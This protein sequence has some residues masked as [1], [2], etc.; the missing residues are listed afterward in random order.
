MKLGGQWITA[1]QYQREKFWVDGSIALRKIVQSG[2]SGR[3][4]EALRQY[5]L[6]EAEYAGT[7]I[8]AKAIAE[9]KPILR[10]YAATIEDTILSHP[11]L[12]KQR[13]ARL[14]TLEPIERE[15]TVAAQKA[16]EEAYLKKVEEERKSGTKWL[17]IDPLNLEELG[18]AKETVAAETARI[19]AIDTTGAE[20]REALLRQIDQAIGEGRLKSASDLVLEASTTLKDSPHLKALTERVKTEIAR[21]SEDKAAADAARIEAE[22]R[23]K[24]ANPP[25]KKSSST[26]D[27]QAKLEEEM[28]SPVAKAVR[29]SQL[30]KRVAKDGAATDQPSPNPRPPRNRHRPHPPQGDHATRQAKPARSHHSSRLDG[31]A[32]RQHR[33]HRIRHSVLPLRAAPPYK[34]RR[35]RRHPAAAQKEKIIQ[36]TAEHGPLHP[37]R[38]PRPRPCRPACF[39]ALQ[40]EKD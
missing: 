6:V 11:Q 29:E 40:K 33:N 30:G 2:Q 5:E 18:K 31:E 39:P 23:T 14:A 19:A 38:Y 37:G 27:E 7:T 17:S 26:R 8:H 4:I 20:V 15:A 28:L 3:L 16:E 13:D 12:L 25:P 9:I 32:R 22:K 34:T 35:H 21:I 24:A 1:D 36:W 10:K